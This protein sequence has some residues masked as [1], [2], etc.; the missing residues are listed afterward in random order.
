MA[1]HSMQIATALTKLW[2]PARE[3]SRASAQAPTMV[4]KLIG[5]AWQLQAIHIPVS[6]LD[7]P[8][9]VTDRILIGHLYLGATCA[10]VWLQG[11]RFQKDMMC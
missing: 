2:W 7:V 10:Y 3:T 8:N 1:R 5:K 9:S 11:N 4:K 6:K